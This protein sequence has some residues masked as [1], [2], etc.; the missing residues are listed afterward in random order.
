MSKRTNSV[1]QGPQHA[2][3]FSW[4]VFSK[5]GVVSVRRTMPQLRNGQFAVK[6]VLR[7]PLSLFEVD[8]PTLT[9]EVPPRR[10]VLPI[11]AQV[12]EP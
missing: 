1:V 3:L 2:D 10:V 4:I 8:V 6:L 5:K 7:V 12:A 9:A 11:S